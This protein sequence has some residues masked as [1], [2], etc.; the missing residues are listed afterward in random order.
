MVGGSC[1][2]CGVMG[3]VE[4][5]ALCDEKDGVLPQEVRKSLPR[6]LSALPPLSLSLQC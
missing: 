4:S 3:G 2:Q 5:W 1:G 6:G